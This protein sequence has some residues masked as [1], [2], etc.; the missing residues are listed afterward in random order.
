MKKGSQRSQGQWWVLLQGLPQQCHLRRQKTQGRKSYGSQSPWSAQAKKYDRREQPV[1]DRDAS[2][3]FVESSYSARYSGWDDDKA[4]SSQEWKADELMD[5]R[6][7]KPVIASW[8]RT[9]EFQSSFSHEKTRHVILEEEPHDRTGTPVVCPQ[10][11]AMLQQFIIGDDEAELDLSWGS[12]SFRV[13][14]QV[15]KR[16]KTNF[17]CYRKRR[18][19]FCDTEN[20]HVC[21]I[22][23]SV[24]HG[25]ELLRQ[26]AFI[27]E[28]KRPHNE[29]NVRHI[30]KIG[31]RTRWDVWSENTWLGRLFVELFVFDWWWTSHQS[32]AHQG[33]RLFRFCI[34]S[35]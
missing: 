35:W 34:V 20:V 23:I 10:R 5:D 16:Q 9:H 11:G 15:R 1:V 26:S 29:T 14:D 3:Q 31:V 30:C 7:V 4:W 13:N 25:K 33:L 6:T 17:K 24:I 8:A 18:K 22:G 2:K 12:W 28:Y 19:T 21:N 32:S 27:W